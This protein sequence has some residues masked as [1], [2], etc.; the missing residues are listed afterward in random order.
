MHSPSFNKYS[1][2]FN[3]YSPASTNTPSLSKHH[4]SPC[5]CA[6]HCGCSRQTSS[7]WCQ[8]GR[9]GWH[10][11]HPAAAG[12]WRWGRYS[13]RGF[14]SWCGTVRC[15]PA[16]PA[17]GA[18][19]DSCPQPVPPPAHRQQTH[20]PSATLH[21]L[22][23]VTDPSAQH[24][25][26]P[27]STLHHLNP[28]TD[29][30]PQH[31]HTHPHQHSTTS[32]PPHPINSS[33]Q[34]T[35]TL[36]NIP[37]PQPSHRPISSTHTHTLINTAPPHIRPSTHQLNTHTHTLASTLHHLTSSHQL[38]SSTHTPSATLHHLTS[39][40]QLI[41]STHT[42]PHQ[43]STMSHPAINSSAQHTHTHSHQHSTTSHPAINSSAQHTHTLTLPKRLM[44]IWCHLPSD[45]CRMMTAP[46]L[47]RPS[48]VKVNVPV[49]WLIIRRG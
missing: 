5:H 16:R 32:P 7:R 39:G 49:P 15:Q 22:N 2:S 40:H 17:R 41:S 18:P 46:V 4:F 11:D 42:H 13:P 34:H 47:S 38:I 23:P 9:R 8:A 44:S 27:S 31:T 43:H 20:T 37:P 12:C 33:A 25:H 14:S 6:Q 19:S 10:S 24:T 21:H 35:H 3:K 45:S 28:V 30:S 48:K 36:I 29:P 1:P 26:T